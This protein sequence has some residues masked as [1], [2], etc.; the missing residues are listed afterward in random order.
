MYISKWLKKIPTKPNRDEDVDC[1]T[2][3]NGLAALETVGQ[4]LT[5]EHTLSK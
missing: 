2:V 1:F 4:F 5:S 3:H